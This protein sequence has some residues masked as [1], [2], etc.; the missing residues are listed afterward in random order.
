MKK[1][2]IDMTGDSTAVLDRVIEAY[3]FPTKIMLADHLGIASSSLA[4]RYK[5]GGFPADIVVRCMAETGATLEWLATGVGPKHEGE[6]FALLRVPRF[7]IVDGQLY[8]AD[9]L[10]L[11][12]TTF[13]PGVT[14]P[15]DPIC[16][17]DGSDQ[18]IID[19]QFSEVYDGDWLI[20][21]EGKTSV[22]A[23]TRIP[24]KKVKV[25]GPGVSFDCSIEDIKIL[26]RVS[27]TIR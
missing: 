20:E 10:L 1:L 22:R 18:R 13:L 11:D 21:V 9:I 7:K 12:H 16:V 4:G 8:E 19:R 24:V 5:R 27:L 15:T 23:L 25:S 6:D 3:G 17:I 14:P 26:G 2:N